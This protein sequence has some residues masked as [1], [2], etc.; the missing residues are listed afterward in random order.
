[1]TKADKAQLDREKLEREQAFL[2][3]ASNPNY[4]VLHPTSPQFAG[5]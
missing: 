2:K 4:N 1:M 5:L 3:S